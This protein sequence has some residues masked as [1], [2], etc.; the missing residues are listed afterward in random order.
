MG[1][2]LQG[3]VIFANYEDGDW[4]PDVPFSNSQRYNLR[5]NNLLIALRMVATV[6]SSYACASQSAR[7]VFCY[8]LRTLKARSPRT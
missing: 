2:T 1:L 3:L 6:I 5:F 4:N 8:L 7:T